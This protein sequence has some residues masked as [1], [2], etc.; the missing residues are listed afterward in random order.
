M[1]SPPAKLLPY[2]NAKGSL[3]TL[4]EKKSGQPI[5]VKVIKEG[6]QAIDF[7][8]KKTLK[9]PLRHQS[10]A[11]V[12]EVLLFGDEHQAWV[13]AKSIFPLSSLTGEGR[14]LRHLGNTPIGYVLFKKNKKLPY[15]R[16]IFEQDGQ[17]G[18][19]NIYHWQGRRILIEEIFLQNFLQVI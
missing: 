9:L 3:T 2:L 18:R 15:I 17:F 8:H 11:W 6:W 4:L 7:A 12:R 13:H 5:Q 16:Q 1:T 19:V 14:R 10:L